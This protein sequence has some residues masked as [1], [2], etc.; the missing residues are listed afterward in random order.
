MPRAHAILLVLVVAALQLTV[1]LPFL[2]LVQWPQGS[3]SVGGG[4]GDRRSHMYM[5][6]S[7]TPTS[8]SSSASS[9]AAVVVAA[10]PQTDAT[11]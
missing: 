1:F 3:H 11:T 8:S 6:P 7:P 10:W 2:P 4:C 5:P 9:V